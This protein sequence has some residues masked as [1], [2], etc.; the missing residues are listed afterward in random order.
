MPP[1]LLNISII[2]S[3]KLAT[4]RPVLFPF[5]GY[6]MMNNKYGKGLM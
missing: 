2:M 1:E 4:T 3:K 6:S 5:T